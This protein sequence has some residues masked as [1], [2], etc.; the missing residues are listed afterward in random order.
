MM[1]IKGLL[2]RKLGPAPVWVYF[3]VGVLIVAWIIKRRQSASTQDD[4]QNGDASAFPNAQPMNYSSDIF[5]NVAAPTGT[6]PTTPTTTP[7]RTLPEKW[8]IKSVWAS[9]LTP[10]VVDALSRNISDLTRGV[11]PSART[12]SVTYVAPVGSPVRTVARSSMIGG[13]V[14]GLDSSLMAIP[15]TQQG[16]TDSGVRVF[17][18]SKMVIPRG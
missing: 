12:K 17:G 1:D 14:T 5:I 16:F 11:I 8:P 10:S 15:G 6:Q 7:V 2:T 18:G 9:K 4:T 3:A 13:T